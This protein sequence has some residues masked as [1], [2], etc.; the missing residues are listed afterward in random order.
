MSKIKVK[1]ELGKCC[2][3]MESA[4]TSKFLAIINS[5]IVF[6]IAKTPRTAG[7]VLTG[8]V[9]DPKNFAYTMNLYYCPFC[10]YWIQKNGD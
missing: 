2:D 9:F 4:I 10:S 1:K 8:E 6:N 3:D 7:N 5:E